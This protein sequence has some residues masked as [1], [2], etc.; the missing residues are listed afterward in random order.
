[1]KIQRQQIGCSEIRPQEKD[2]LQQKPVRIYAVDAQKNV[3]C[4]QPRRICSH[5][6]GLQDKIYVE[7]KPHQLLQIFCEAVQILFC[8][9]DT[10]EHTLE[11]VWHSGFV[12]I[13][14]NRRELCTVLHMSVQ[15]NP[16]AEILGNC[17]VTTSVNK[18]TPILQKFKWFNTSSLFRM[19]GQ[20]YNKVEMGHMFIRKAKTACTATMMATCISGKLS[21]IPN[22]TYMYFCSLKWQKHTDFIHNQSIYFNFFLLKNAP[23]MPFIRGKI[24]SLMICCSA[25]TLHMQCDIT[26]LCSSSWHLNSVQDE[27]VRSDHVISTQS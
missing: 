11:G 22:M 12:T 18:H 27:R 16:R 26:V 7:K 9:F 4:E 8:G 23:I 5:I 6:E 24:I 14:L 21:T 10:C 1:M 13:P 19:N 15:F 25:S 17:T 3:L 20:K 2:N